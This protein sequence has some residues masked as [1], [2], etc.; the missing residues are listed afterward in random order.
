MTE[1]DEW[2]KRNDGLT[3]EMMR[4]VRTMSLMKTM[5]IFFDCAH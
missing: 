3:D 2:E 4:T 1:V 5:T